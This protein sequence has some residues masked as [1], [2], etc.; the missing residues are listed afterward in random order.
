MKYQWKEQLTTQTACHNTSKNE[1]I[2][3]PESLCTIE[4]MSME[5]F[6]K[7]HPD[8]YQRTFVSYGLEHI[9]FCK[10]EI[11]HHAVTGTLAIPLKKNPSKPNIT[12]GFCLMADRLIFLDDRQIVPAI[13]DDMKEYPL[14]D[15]ASPSLFLFDFLEYLLKDDT[16]FLQQYEENLSR[17]EE[18]LMN[19]YSQNFNQKLFE[20]RK[21]LSSLGAYYQQLYD[22][23]ETLHQYAVEND[24]ERD[25][26]LFELLA[27]KASRLYAIVQMMNNYSI[28][29]REMHQSIIGMH[30]NEIMKILTIVTT[31]F[32]PLTLITGWYGM[33][34]AH[35]PELT[36][37]YGYLIV[38][39]LC[40]LVILIEILI[41][42]KKKWF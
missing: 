11:L 28:Q 31:I 23:G 1:N 15:A 5:E 32:M 20:V 18:C 17:L 10:A 24:A 29:L 38:I 40:L 12:F 9:G 39:V 36:S 27:Q 26:L 42:K 3:H 33:N 41:F 13:L 6:R 19:M 34:F 35:M 4:I 22:M 25:S 30:Q 8:S 2:S 16:I 21:D 14:T 37:K 7:N